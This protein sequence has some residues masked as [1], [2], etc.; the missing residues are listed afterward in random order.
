[1][2]GWVARPLWK[3][4]WSHGIESHV[5]SIGRDREREGEFVESVAAQKDKRATVCFGIDMLMR[6]GV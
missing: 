5:D 3:W 2:T 1:M 4:R 6:G